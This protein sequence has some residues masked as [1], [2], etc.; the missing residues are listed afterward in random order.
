M[1]SRGAFV[2]ACIV[3][4]GAIAA[5]ADG[6][7]ESTAAGTRVGDRIAG[8]SSAF[9]G[10][11]IDTY[12]LSDGAGGVTH[13]GVNLPLAV[14]TAPAPPTATA[15]VPDIARATTFFDHVVFELG[16]PAAGLPA[17]YDVQR[18]DLYFFGIPLAE[19]SS[20]DCRTEPMPPADLVPGGY[21]IVG[22]ACV[23]GIGVRALDSTSPEL[24]LTAPA[25]FTATMVLGYHA[26]KIAF[27][28]PMVA[29][30]TLE[31]R[32]SF[33]LAVP[34]PSHLDRK[35]LWPARFDGAYDATN[36]SYAFVFSEF[37]PL[38]DVAPIE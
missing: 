28:E 34:R 4:A 20:I 16:P 12:A 22:D 27:L 37:V 14:L 18:L 21:V 6:T 11:R 32:V 8:S 30:A 29:R 19:Q 2:A 7:N 36:D 15:A 23:S 26:G 38:S 33:T 24:A 1:T 31:A 17:A 5:C 25:P 13:V 35:T 9:G 10:G 3:V